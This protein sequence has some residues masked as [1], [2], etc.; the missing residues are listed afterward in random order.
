MVLILVISTSTEDKCAT[1]ISDTTLLEFPFFVCV[2]S[3]TFSITAKSVIVSR[4]GSKVF[5][6]VEQRVSNSV[7]LRAQIA[8]NRFLTN[9]I[10]HVYVQSLPANDDCWIKLQPSGSFLL[11]I[12]EHHNKSLPSYSGTHQ[13]WFALSQPPEVHHG[14]GVR[15]E[16]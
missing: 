9:P 2:G 16:W 12:F 7:E 8:R 1:K 14:Y 15:W 13:H 4:K 10:G 5:V 6:F 3:T 11:V